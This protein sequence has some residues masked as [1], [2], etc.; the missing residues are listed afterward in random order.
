VVRVP[1]VVRGRRRVRVLV[2]L[3]LVV[4]RGGR[5]RPETRDVTRLCAANARGRGLVLVSY[6]LV[7]ATLSSRSLPL[8]PRQLLRMSRINHGR[9]HPSSEW[10]P[11]VT[12]LSQQ[13][14]RRKGPRRYL[15]KQFTWCLPLEITRTVLSLLRED[16]DGQHFVCAAM[17][18]CKEWKVCST[19]SS[20]VAAD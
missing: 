19:S 15:P 17:R 4:H 9:T 6:V 16:E 3:H 12:T 8:R 18:V 14:R 20:F 7:A 10:K 1:D 13:R 11:G 5:T 2:L